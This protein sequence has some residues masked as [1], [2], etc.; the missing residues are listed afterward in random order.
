MVVVMAPQ[1]SLRCADGRA[2]GQHVGCSRLLMLPCV[3]HIATA[4]A[5]IQ[6]IAPQPCVGRELPAGPT[7]PT[8]HLPTPPLPLCTAAVVCHHLIQ[9]KLILE[10]PHRMQ[11]LMCAGS[12]RGQLTAMPHDDDVPKCGQAAPVC[13][14]GTPP[15]L[16]MNYNSNNNNTICSLHLPG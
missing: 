15:T 5:E 3:S 1:W 7:G 9:T 12:M 11:R 13:I 4:L 14:C 10:S 2:T 16:F 6:H 8:P